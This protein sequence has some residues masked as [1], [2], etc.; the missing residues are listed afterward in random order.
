MNDTMV[1]LTESFSVTV[2]ELLLFT[3]PKA[4]VPLHSLL[5]DATCYARPYMV[6]FGILFI[7]L[8]GATG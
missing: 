4:L 8:C 6:R 2:V 5:P 1:T 7:F 3:K